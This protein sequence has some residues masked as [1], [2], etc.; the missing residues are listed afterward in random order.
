MTRHRLH[1]LTS[2]NPALGQPVPAWIGAAAIILS[3]V[4]AGVA[5]IIIGHHETSGVVLLIIAAI[6]MI[7]GIALWVAK[8]GPG[9]ISRHHG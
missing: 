7:A 9:R 3:L 1:K 4:L 5:A 6:S 8:L 2:D